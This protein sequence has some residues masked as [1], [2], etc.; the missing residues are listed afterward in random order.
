MS[1]WTWRWKEYGRLDIVVHNAAIMGLGPLADVTRRA[2]LDHLEPDVLAAVTLSQ[3]A[4]PVFESQRYGRLVL[5]SSTAYFGGC[6]LVVIRDLEGGHGLA[7]PVTGA[8]V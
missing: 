7:G 3:L 4:W 8:A 6:F 1:W 5:T 2:I